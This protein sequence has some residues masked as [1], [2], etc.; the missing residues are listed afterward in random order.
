MGRV[1][2]GLLDVVSP[3]VVCCIRIALDG[4]GARLV[5]ILIDESQQ[6]RVSK[7]EV[8]SI[9]SEL[10]KDVRLLSGAGSGQE[11]EPRVPSWNFFSLS[12]WV[13]W[14]FFSPFLVPL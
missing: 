13:A 9:E 11:E 14:H 8:G 1:V 7:P 12:F 3:I 10:P 4:N 6:F 5:N 2:G